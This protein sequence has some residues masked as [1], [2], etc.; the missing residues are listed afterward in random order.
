M[1]AILDGL[2]IKIPVSLDDTTKLITGE[3]AKAKEESV[4]TATCT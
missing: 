4:P 3:I 1:K 2:Q